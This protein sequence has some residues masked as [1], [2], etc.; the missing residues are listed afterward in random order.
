MSLSQAITE[1]GPFEGPFNSRSPEFD[2]NYLASPA[3]VSRQLHVSEGT[4]SV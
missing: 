1:Q 4:L 3:Q 2:P